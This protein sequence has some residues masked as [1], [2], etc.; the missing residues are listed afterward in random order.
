[1]PGQLGAVATL[2]LLGNGEMC[3]SRLAKSYNGFEVGCRDTPHR[4]QWARGYTTACPHF[5]RANWK[6]QL[7]CFHRDALACGVLS[8][9]H[10]QV[11]HGDD[12]SRLETAEVMSDWKNASQGQG[13]AFLLFPATNQATNIKADEQKREMIPLA[14]TL[15]PV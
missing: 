12:P 10:H 6:R 1:R 7:P 3:D 4:S 11:G 5:T 9:I 15:S 13:S 14:R 8:G 2:A